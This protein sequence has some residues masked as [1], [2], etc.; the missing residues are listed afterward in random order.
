M[1]VLYNPAT[2]FGHSHKESI[3]QPSET[4]VRYQLTNLN[5]LNPSYLSIVLET[6]TE[7]VGK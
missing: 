3:S 6:S 7:E 2:P 5:Q 1:Q 4:T